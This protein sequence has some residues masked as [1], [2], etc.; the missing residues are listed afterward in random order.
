[1]GVSKHATLVDSPMIARGSVLVQLASLIDRLPTP[2]RSGRL[3]RY[4]RK[5]LRK[6]GHFPFRRTVERRLRVLPE[7]VPAKRATAPYT[8]VADQV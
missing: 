3:M 2:P 6:D 7:I 5:L 8:W 4:L 1:M